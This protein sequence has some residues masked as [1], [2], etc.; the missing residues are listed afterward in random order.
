MLRLIIVQTDGLGFV[1]ENKVKYLIT[2][3]NTLMSKLNLAVPNV[4]SS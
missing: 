3:K 4:T 2:F 1:G